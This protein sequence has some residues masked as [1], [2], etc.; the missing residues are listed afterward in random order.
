MRPGT[1]T[2]R[3]PDRAG[4]LPPDDAAWRLARRRS[5][6][7]FTRRVLFRSSRASSPSWWRWQDDLLTAIIPA[8]RRAPGSLTRWGRP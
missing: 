5:M 3:A 6:R 7:A 2:R 4:T 8:L 1:F